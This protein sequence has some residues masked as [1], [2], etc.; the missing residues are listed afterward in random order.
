MKKILALILVLALSLSMVACGSKDEP[1]A[2]D[3]ADFLQCFGKFF[4]VNDKFH[5]FVSCVF[6]VFYI[7]T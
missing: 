6:S 3:T 4:A 1:A 2:D 7:I 5:V